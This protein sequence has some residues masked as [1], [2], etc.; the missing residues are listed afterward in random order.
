MTEGWAG[1]GAEGVFDVA[2]HTLWRKAVCR[3]RFSPVRAH[4][5]WQW[6]LLLLGVTR[7][8]ATNC[9]I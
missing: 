7:P 2:S 8:V 6:A 1:D 4:W 5:A 3:G 9:G